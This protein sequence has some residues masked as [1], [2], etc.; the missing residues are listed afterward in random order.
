MKL[1]R[2]IFALAAA[3]LLFSS[4]ASAQLISGEAA[5]DFTLTDVNG[6]T[7]SL[8]DQQGKFV[9]LEWI[10]CD[11]PFVKKH[12]NSGNMQS[13]QAEFTGKDVVW[14]AIASSAPGK[15]GHY[16]EGEWKN[17]IN[18]NEINASAVLLDPSGEV[19]RLYGAKTT[20]HMYVINP[21]GNL[22][23]QGAIDSVPSA[24]SADIATATNYVTQAL[25]E[26]M[27]G[28]AVSET[29]TKA[30]GCSVKY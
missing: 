26:A 10:N 4:N 11:C 15:Q 28:N 6:N 19:G 23:Y 20:P 18:K 22:I 7:H 21:E 1:K 29:S 8:A 27:S 30:Y 17:L 12:Y 5:P 16:S 3:L 9:V 25:N 13:L 24:D 14:Y 2:N